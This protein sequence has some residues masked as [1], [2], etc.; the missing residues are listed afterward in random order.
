[1]PFSTPITDFKKIRTDTR[2]KIHWRRYTRIIMKQKKKKNGDLCL[3]SSVIQ[4]TFSLKRVIP[5]Y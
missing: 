1:M 2:R 4:E 3:R 5:I